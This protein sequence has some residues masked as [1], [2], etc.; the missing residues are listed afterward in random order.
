MA[1]K[2]SLLSRIF[3]MELL[4]DWH[5]L[6]S[7]ESKNDVAAVSLYVYD[8]HKSKTMNSR[9]FKYKTLHL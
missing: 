1:E 8:Q 7:P 3:E 2:A 9:R 6:G 5:V 4:M